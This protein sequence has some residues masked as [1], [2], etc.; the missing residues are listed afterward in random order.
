MSI[1][2]IPGRQVHDESLTSN[3]IL[4]DTIDSVDIKD[5]SIIDSDISINAAIQGSKIK[6][7]SIPASKIVNSSFANFSHTH[8]A[9][10]I[11]TDST[12]NFVTDTEKTIWNAK[13][14]T[15][16]ATTSTNGLMSS[17]DKTKLDGIATSATNVA[18]SITNGNIKINGIET[19]VYTLPA[20][21]TSSTS[22]NA[23][24][25]TKLQTSRTISLLGDITA[26][27]T[28]DGSA[29]L[30]LT[31]TL[32]NS[33]VV[34]GTYPK[35][36]VN[37][38]GLVTNGSSLIAS[39]IP[40]L[41]WSKITSGKPTT[42]SGYGIT[43]TYTSTQIDTLL[44]SNS[45]VNKLTK[46][47]DSPTSTLTIGNITNY[48]FSIITNNITRLNIPA[49]GGLNVSGG[50]LKISASGSTLTSPRIIGVSDMVDGNGVRF[51]FGDGNNAWQTGYHQAMQLWSFHTMVLC[52]DRD[53]ETSMPFESRDTMSNIGV[54][55]RNT[56]TTSPALVVDGAVS[57]TGDLQQ[58]RNSSGT[59]LAR[60]TK[61]GVFNS[62][63]SAVD[64]SLSATQV[65]NNSTWTKVLFN[66]KNKD[67]LD[68][69]NPATYRFTPL[70]QGRYLITCG[71]AYVHHDSGIRSMTIYKSG[72]DTG[73]VMT[74]ETNTKNN[75][76]AVYNYTTTLDLNTNEYIEFYTYQN[77]GG[78]LN[79]YNA[80][81]TITKI[82]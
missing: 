39:D 26:S 80:W 70:Y 73:R 64:I 30:S 10:D 20:S 24:T 41:D 6:D 68:E 11:T 33:G 40:N 37:T 47:G 43:D 35:V 29:N 55:V 62:I 5:G 75:V 4:N 38:K 34:A 69:Y 1:Q 56:T 25:A 52:G 14:S 13:A 66:T 23:A 32:A 78:T 71:F 63:A 27:G 3:K 49:S 79:I 28:F 61:D 46:G 2:K 65:I 51:Q 42:L 18:S 44:A 53:S 77:R 81:A 16:I 67:S 22:G 74:L 60:I 36:T 50:D 15:A 48:D 7:N 72:V 8:L 9:T 57:Q 17:T 59:V 12:H 54:L 76:N 45:G 21:I 31:S 82:L 19:T 58:W